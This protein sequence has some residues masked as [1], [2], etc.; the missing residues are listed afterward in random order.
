MTLRRLLLPVLLI[1]ALLAP[2]ATSAAAPGI[3]PERFTLTVRLL[4]RS[5]QT[6][7]VQPTVT[8]FKLDDPGFGYRGDPGRI[9][10]RQGR[11]AV[12]A[13][14]RTPRP[15]LEPSY[16]FISHPSLRLDRNTTLTLDARIGKPVGLSSDNPAARGGT[17]SFHRY[18]RIAG[19][20]IGTFDELDPRFHPT[21]AATVPGSGS[22]TFAYAQYRRAA[23]PQLELHLRG[24]NGF[25]VAAY[26]FL[27]SPVPEI[28]GTFQAVYAGAGTTAELARVDA[29][30][31]LVAIE[32]VEGTTYAEAFRRTANI[33]AAGGRVAYLVVRAATASARAAAEDEDRPAL[34]T[35]DGNSVTGR[36]FLARVKAA[37]RTVSVVLDRTPTTR[38][39]LTYGG[40]TDLSKARVLRPRTRDL[41]AVRTTYHGDAA[42]QLREVGASTTIAGGNAFLTYSEPA[43]APQTRTEYFTPGTWRLSACGPASACAAAT[44]RLVKGR[45]NSIAWNKAVAG[46]TFRGTTADRTYGERPWAWRK[47]GAFD[48]A[49]PMFGDSAGRPR[50]A[51]PEIG[52]DGS[53]ALYRDGALVER[54][55]RP[56]GAHIP[57]QAGE[58]TY[59][60]TAEATRAAAWWPLSRTVKADWT[61][62][63]SAA[64][65]GKPLPLVTVRFDPAVD[66]RN[67]VRAER[68]IAIPAYVERAGLPIRT[69]QLSVW[70]SADDGRTWRKASGHRTPAG[71]RVD[72]QTPSSGFVSLRAKA[73][74]AAGNRVEQTIVRAFGV[75]TE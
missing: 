57:V 28:H 18:A 39:E 74:D 1:C 29:R 56:T 73:V 12:H 5:G 41:A 46:P 31:K 33:K 19:T 27:D 52:D 59:R 11:Y 25:E 64:N 58:S 69:K 17:Y 22:A 23:E 34:P 44:Q 49:L 48:L 60:L 43:A 8:I 26:G 51:L 2:A 35:L 13:T 45:A 6:A 61:F 72:V 20:T 21:Y 42:D 7:A 3:F 15:G 67:R 30:G 40:D 14:I 37:E 62:R 36:L 50:E 54:V 65:E 63:S 70:T 24:A 68:R 4:D 16:S 32:L 9:V 10:L 55:P 53:I 66:L 75:E 38:Y 71:W 47:D